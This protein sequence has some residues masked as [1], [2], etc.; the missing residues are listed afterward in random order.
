M[1]STAPTS[2]SRP[3]WLAIFVLA[4][5]A[6]GAVAG[7]LAVAGGTNVSTAILTGTVALLLALAH[8]LSG[9]P[10]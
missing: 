8:Y 7:L 2:S 1:T 4:A 5:A 6:V 10:R 3:L 9:S